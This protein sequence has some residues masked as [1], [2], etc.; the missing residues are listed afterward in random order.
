MPKAQVRLAPGVSASAETDQA[1]V[2]GFPS[3]RM[4]VRLKFKF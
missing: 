1:D 4:L 3:N 2:G